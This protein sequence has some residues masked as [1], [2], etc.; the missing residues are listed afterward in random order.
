MSELHAS[1]TTGSPRYIQACE[2][3][4][5]S[6]PAELTCL[7]DEVRVRLPPLHVDEH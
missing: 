6:L 5:T 7:Q 2:L 4:D 1:E 3:M